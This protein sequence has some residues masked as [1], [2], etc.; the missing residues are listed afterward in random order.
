MKRICLSAALLLLLCACT[1]A[2]QASPLPA[3]P[4]ALS[5]IRQ[6]MTNGDGGIYTRYSADAPNTSG[7]LSESQGLMMRY[8]V[9]ADDRQAFDSAWGYVQRHMLVQDLVLWRTEAADTAAVNATL[10]DLRIIGALLDGAALWEDIHL[11]AAAQRM[12]SA[13]LAACAPGGELRD[14]YDWQSRDTSSQLTLCYIDLPVIA[15]LARDDA[16][17]QGIYDQASALLQNGYLGDTLPFYHT[18]YRY[19]SQAYISDTPINM[20]QALYSAL[21]AQ[22]NGS[23]RPQTVDWLLKRMQ[24]GQ[25]LYAY[26]HPDTGLAAT[27]MRSTAV[28]AL[29]SILLRESGHPKQA[30]TAI[31]RML[32]LSI[33]DASH[34]LYG[35]FGD[36]QGSNIHSFDNLTAL[37]AIQASSKGESVP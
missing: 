23:G 3:A 2:P 34:P 6:N 1:P 22:R 10:D 19:D 11:R 24:D 15:R 27:D 26:Y 33:Q 29:A 21:H 25:E 36:R 28:Y 18:R 5:F 32:A 9:L 4:A 20:V 8:G 7:I 17:W 14:F 35:A 31:Q 16:R 12:A 37:L 13:L 30:D